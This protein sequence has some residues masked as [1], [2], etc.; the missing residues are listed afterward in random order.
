MRWR[1]LL[2]ESVN[3]SFLPICSYVHSI[4]LFWGKWFPVKILMTILVEVK[5]RKRCNRIFRRLVINAKTSIIL[6]VARSQ[7]LYLLCEPEGPEYFWHLD[8][9][10]CRSFIR[11][12]FEQ[13]KTPQQFY[14]EKW[15]YTHNS[16]WID[17]LQGQHPSCHKSGIF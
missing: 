14:Y 6:M 1:Y 8:C 17:Q 15:L 5:N 2:R 12:W 13:E 7:V 3:T 4:S 16:R 11:T 10:K 9:L